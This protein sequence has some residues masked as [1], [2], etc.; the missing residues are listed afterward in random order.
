MT[1]RAR[2]IDVSHHQPPIDWEALK[3]GGFVGA[4][5]KLTEG[6]TYV[7]PAAAKHWEGAKAAGLL[8]GGYCFYRPARDPKKQAAHF[9]RVMDDLGGATLP[10]GLD[11][12]V[13]DGNVKTGKPAVPNAA[14]L[15]GCRVWLAEVERLTG[16]KPT[17]YS[18]APFLDAHGLAGLAENA[19]LWLAAYVPEKRLRLPKGWAS[20]RAWQ[21]SGSGTAPGVTGPVDLNVFNG[22]E[23]SLRNWARDQKR[24]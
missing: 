15:A 20:W 9:A 11:I 23:K 3:A 21:F 6:E 1:E 8:V 2:L 18:Y 14:I 19:E 24:G 16:W 5:V 22:D 12:E 10:P 4:V 7:D 17:V 13:D